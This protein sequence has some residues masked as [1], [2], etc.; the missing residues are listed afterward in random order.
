MK[1]LA[2]GCRLCSPFTFIR[3]GLG[4]GAGVKDYKGLK[5]WEATGLTLHEDARGGDKVGRVGSLY[6]VAIV[7]V[8]N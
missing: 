6:G 8:K 2:G 7:V 5:L 4:A 1:V 3:M